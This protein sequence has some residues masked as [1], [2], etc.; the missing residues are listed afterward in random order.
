MI[1]FRPLQGFQPCLLAAV[2]SDERQRQRAA[3]RQQYLDRVGRDE[4]RLERA[5]GHTYVVFPDRAAADEVMREIAVTPIVADGLEWPVLIWDE[6]AGAG[7]GTLEATDGRV[8]VGHPWT[9]A[10]RAWLAAYVDGWRAV[11]ILDML[12][13]DWTPKDA[14]G[15]GVADAIGSLSR[16]G[17]GRATASGQGGG[18]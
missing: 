17:E 5:L 8:A 12:P 9:G 6:D 14:H 16:A 2:T 7:I 18:A 11:Q 15:P 3:R 10:E 4:Q 1:S 13:A